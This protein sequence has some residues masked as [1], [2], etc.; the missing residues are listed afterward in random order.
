MRSGVVPDVYRF[1]APASTKLRNI[2]DGRIIQ[3]PQRIFVKRFDALFETNFNAVREEII[4]PQ[5]ILLL[6][7]CE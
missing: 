3:S 6:D 1:F 7:F 5:K 2:G 4:L